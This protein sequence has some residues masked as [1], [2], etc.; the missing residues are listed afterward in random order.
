MIQNYVDV[1]LH[2]HPCTHLEVCLGTESSGRFLRSRSPG[3]GCDWVLA[4]DGGANPL[5]A[6]DISRVRHSGRGR[7]SGSLS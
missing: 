4:P 3:T 7:G 5:T 2:A 1:E 6:A